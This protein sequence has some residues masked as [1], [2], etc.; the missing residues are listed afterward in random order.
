M[1]FHGLVFFCIL[2]SETYGDADEETVM[3]APKQVHIAFGDSLAEMVIVWSTRGQCSTE[4]QY[5]T[6]PFG[7]F[8]TV[9]GIAV[10]LPGENVVDFPHLHKVKLTNLQPET[11]YYY[12][13]VS[14]GVISGPF[15]FKTPPIGQDWEP[16]FLIYG[17]LGVHSNS[18]AHLI[19]E[20]LTGKYSAV[21]HVG[22][23]G[24]N[25]EEMIDFGPHKGE[26]VGDVFMQEIEEMASH[27]PYMTAPGN[28]EI[29][30]DTFNNYRYRFAMPNSGWPIPLSKMWYS[31][32]IGPVHFLS[33]SSEV[34]FTANGQYV[35][36]QKEWIQSDLDAA[37]RNRDRVPWVIAFGHRPMYCSNDDGDDCTKKDS[38]VRLGLEDL[39][40]RNGVDIVLQAHE[41][42]YERLWPMYKGVVLSKNYTNPAAP[43]QLITGAA[44]SK[45]GIDKMNPKPGNWSAFRMDN[46]SFNSYG[47][48]KVYNASHLYWEQVAV[49][50]G[51]VLDSIWVIQESHGPF[52]SNKLQP[53]VKEQIDVQIQKDKETEKKIEESKKPTNTG[54]SDFKEKVTNAIKSADTKLIVGV[55]FGVFVVLFMLVVCIVRRCRRKPK[56][57]RR[58]ETLD[59]GK[60]FYTNVK[61]DEKEADDFE[62]DVTDGRTKLLT[63]NGID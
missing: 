11:V 42:S 3:C 8:S 55:S 17:D 25:L 20:V 39:F 52:H 58:W 35:Q 2:L 22:D 48:L 37:N 61:G 7:D 44:G 59:Y 9:H 63:E 50:G 16:E 51:E 29:E 21:L 32:D 49:F 31:L 34:F 54:F 15:Y 1:K 46:R 18:T 36:S 41:H 38:L 53:E 43:I 60:K 26:N 57:Y 30:L 28:H 33:Y 23:F 27:F 24:Y 56:S 6:Q 47:T 10:E 19:R 62:A 4:V 40:Y 13:P 5:S 45:H 14:D 12:T